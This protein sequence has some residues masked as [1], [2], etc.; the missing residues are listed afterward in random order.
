MSYALLDW[1]AQKEIVFLFLLPLTLSREWV[2][3]FIAL[4]FDIYIIIYK[5]CSLF[6]IVY[7]LHMTLSFASGSTE[8]P[9][10]QLA[11]RL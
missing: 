3:L 7:V 5:I 1:I 10:L 11:R 4:L 8:K 6:Y 9:K 2:F